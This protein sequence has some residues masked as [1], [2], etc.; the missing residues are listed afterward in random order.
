MRVLLLALALLAVLKI[1]AHESAYR[2]ATEEALVS[3][4]RARAADA[5]ARVSLFAASSGSGGLAPHT[6]DWM[7]SAVPRI[8]VGNPAIPVYLWQFDHELW[9]ARYRQPYLILGDGP[10]GLSCTYDILAGSAEVDR[11]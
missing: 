2:S 11:S 5:C 8:T 4:Y 9:D 1:W 3:A 6:I 10:A 7:S